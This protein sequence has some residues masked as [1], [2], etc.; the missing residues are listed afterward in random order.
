MPT[1]LAASAPPLLLIANRDELAARSLESVVA[2]AGYRVLRAYSAD[3]ALEQARSRRPDAILLGTDLGTLDGFSLCRLLRQ[4]P[5]VT[6]STPILLTY[7]GPAPRQRRIEAYRAGACSLWGQPLDTE[8]FVLSLG[9]QLRAK[10]DADRA[11]EA[12]LVD[13]ASGLSNPAGLRRRVRELVAE[14]VRRMVPVSL[15][16]LDAEEAA[17]GR[18]ELDGAVVDVVR[19]AARGSDHVARLGTGRFAVAAPAT[20]PDGAARLGERL[21][22]LV[23]RAAQRAGAPMER[24]RV[25]FDTLAEPASQAGDPD[26][27]IDRAVLACAVPA[28]EGRVH[29]WSGARGP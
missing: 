1:P 22:S 26:G 9:A 23:D 21:L 11:R 12:G 8:E 5:A 13:A 3:S 20:G 25:G 2:P 10:F 19:D 7:P 28:G 17:A 24:C 4:D 14:A 6:P 15:V 16:V 27:L 18:P 29:R